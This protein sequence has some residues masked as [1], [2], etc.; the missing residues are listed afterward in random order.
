MGEHEGWGKT[1]PK[2]SKY[3]DHGNVF[4]RGTTRPYLRPMIRDRKV[5]GC[6]WHGV[7]FGGHHA[8]AMSF[9]VLLLPGL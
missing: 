1:P 3:E 9:G 5:I 7:T 4:L 8:K 6:I 2:C